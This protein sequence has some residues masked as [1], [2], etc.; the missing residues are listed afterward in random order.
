MI[1]VRNLA[2]T[3]GEGASVIRA[4]NGIDFNVAARLASRV[5]VNGGFSTGK[6]VWDGCANLA[7]GV[8]PKLYGNIDLTAAATIA[9]SQ[10]FCHQ[11]TP[12]QNQAKVFVVYPLPY[13]FQVSA[14]FQ[15]TVGPVIRSLYPEP[16]ADA[17]RTLGR[18]LA[19]GAR[20]ATVD[21]V[22]PGSQY[23]RRQNQLDM[24]FTRT[25]KLGAS[26]LQA[27]FDVYNLFNSSAVLA[28]SSAYTNS[29]SIWPRV[30]SILAARLFKFGMQLDWK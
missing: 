20:T 4:V 10:V 19:G 3:F 16:T 8:Q 12:W 13:E 2:V 14:N 23:D 5:T 18:A 7:A 6:S 15:S 30:S 22:A 1:E 24:R 29:T 28:T 9:P 11:E 17:Q 25:F 26:R 21:I 27:Q